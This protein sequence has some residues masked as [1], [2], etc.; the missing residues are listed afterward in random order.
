MPAYEIPGFTRSY[1][2]SADLSAQWFKFVK[3]AGGVIAPVTSA[4]DAGIGVLQNKPRPKDQG[5]VALTSNAAFAG[6]VMVDGVTRVFASKAFA[7]GVPVFLDADGSVTDVAA[8]NHA[9]GVSE[10]PSSGA[11][12]LVSVLLKPL[13]ALA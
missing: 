8:A 7:A 11:G 2:P 9:V 10:T 3:L 13:G 1:E 4:V 6:T 12:A 5:T